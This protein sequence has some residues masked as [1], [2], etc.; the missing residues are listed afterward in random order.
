MG[1]RFAATQL[2][3]LQTNELCKKLCVNT[4]E[5]VSASAAQKS[6]L[7]ARVSS[8]QSYLKLYCHLFITI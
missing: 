1:L 3:A 7:Q 4:Q 5:R 8:G 2:P 6:M